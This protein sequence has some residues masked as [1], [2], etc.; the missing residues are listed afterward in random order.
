MTGF[1]YTKLLTSAMI[2]PNLK[3]K[4]KTS[5]DQKF[6]P[7]SHLENVGR[8]EIR[9]NEGA[10][11][12]TAACPWGENDEIIHKAIGEAMSQQ[13]AHV[14]AGKLLLPL[15]FPDRDWLAGIVTAPV[16]IAD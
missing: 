1:I 11:H 15:T 16:L 2:K 12:I 5:D 9:C 7:L 4:Q 13:I 10:V 3:K 8:A 14:K 6:R